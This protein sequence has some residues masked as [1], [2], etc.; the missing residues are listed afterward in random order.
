MKITRADFIK[1]LGEQTTST[2]I[3]IFTTTVPAM[4]K[5]N[6]P[7]FGQVVKK[8]EINCQINF[9]YENGVNRVRIKENKKPT[10]KAGP[11]QW[12]DRDN[13]V[14]SHGDKKYLH[15]RVLSYVNVNFY[16]KGNKVSRTS[17][18]EVSSFFAKKHNYSAQGVLPQHEVVIRDFDF[19]SIDAVKMN[20]ILYE[21]ID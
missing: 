16:L 6:N 1:L 3:N 8:S 11:R 17:F 21:F 5:T 10:F 2:F 15:V 7:F 12:G 4:T 20:K 9:N 18:N 14:V 19:E 13:C